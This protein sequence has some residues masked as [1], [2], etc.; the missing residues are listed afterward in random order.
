[1]TNIYFC[2]SIRAGRADVGLYAKIVDKLKQ[3]GTVLTEFVADKKI[4][5]SGSEMEGGDRAIHDKDV[6]LL[7]K[8]DGNNLM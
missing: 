4:T 8:A 3:F 1:M 2:G 7:E 6:S 5:E